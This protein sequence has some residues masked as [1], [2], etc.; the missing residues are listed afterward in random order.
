MY[1]NYTYM[2]Q[3]QK[4]AA[5]IKANAEEKCCISSQHDNNSG[6]RQQSYMG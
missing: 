4:H 5:Y 6:K 3:M 1:F 2:L